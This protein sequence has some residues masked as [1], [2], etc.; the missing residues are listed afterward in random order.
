MILNRCFVVILMSSMA[1]VGTASVSAEE[2]VLK[3]GT[4]LQGKVLRITGDM[5]L[6]GVPREDVASID[7]AALPDAIKAGAI[8]PKFKVKDMAGESIKIPDKKHALTL[9]KFWASW[10][11]YCRGDIPMI[12]EA[13]NEFN[14]QGFRVVGVSIDQDVS[15]L[16][17]FLESQPLNYPVVTTV[18][19][20]E[21]QALV[22]TQYQVEGVPAYA[23]VNAA[24]EIVWS[25]SG[26]LNAQGIDLASIIKEQLGQ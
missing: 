23:M 4:Q 2:I 21:E 24:G 26:S 17:T 18:G 7:G 19:E 22:A 14:S 13:V 1:W 11:P 10:C 6:V 12:S 25:V 15:A 20:S 9:L 3:E 16:K 5:V 8:A